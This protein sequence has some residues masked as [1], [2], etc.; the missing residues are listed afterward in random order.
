MLRGF[1]SLQF[2]IALKRADRFIMGS[3]LFNVFPVSLLPLA[4]RMA[5]GSAQLE[6]FQTR[7]FGLGRI[8]EVGERLPSKCQFA[9]T[10][11]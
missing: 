7:R 3:I 5:R 4:A 2:R 8:F 9:N 6:A 11:E 1:R 10:Q